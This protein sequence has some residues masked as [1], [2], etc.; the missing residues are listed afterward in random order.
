MG[1]VGTGASGDV[2]SALRQV[3]VS[4]DATSHPSKDGAVSPQSLWSALLDGQSRVVDQFSQS[5]RRYVVTR[6]ALDDT[7]G[8]QLTGRERE[9]LQGALACLDDSSIARRLGLS[10]STVSSY[11]ARALA[12]LGLRRNSLYACGARGRILRVGGQQWG[13][14]SLPPLG[15]FL[16]STLTPAEREVAL[17]LIEKSSNLEV[18]RERHRSVRTVAN[19]IASVFRKLDVSGRSEML[20]RLCAA[21]GAASSVDEHVANPAARR[22]GQA[23]PIERRL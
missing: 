13:V 2:C 23:E 10:V 11:R 12:K 4:G 20:A 21:A 1:P 8:P 16:P 15:A 22:A 9:I 19:Q 17:L 6:P 7:P 3:V 18:A 5:G 14:L